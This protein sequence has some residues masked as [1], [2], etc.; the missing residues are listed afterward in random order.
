MAAPDSAQ[1]LPETFRARSLLRAIV[2]GADTL[3]IMVLLAL[4]TG[5]SGATPRAV[6]S[7]FF[8][9]ALFTGCSAFY[10]RLTVTVSERSV[11]VRTF[12]DE[13]VVAFADIL[14]VDVL[15]GLLG[16]SYSIRTRRGPVRFDSLLEDHQRLC[17]LIIDRAGLSAQR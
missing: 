4:I 14:R 13:H 12:I 15:P 17:T 2:L 9:I 3:W 8:F 10:E 11:T 6:I 5:G 1:A 16:T 7:A